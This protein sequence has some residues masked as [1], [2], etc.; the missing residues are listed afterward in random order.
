MENFVIDQFSEMDCNDY[1]Q[2]YRWQIYFGVFLFLFSIFMFE[3][4]QIIALRWGIAFNE[5]NA[6]Q[7]FG[8]V[9]F[10]FFGGQPITCGKSSLPI[11]NGFEIIWG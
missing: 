1:H 4:N 8:D 2:R 11:E 10:V 9:F 5:Y 7:L 3:I 6:M